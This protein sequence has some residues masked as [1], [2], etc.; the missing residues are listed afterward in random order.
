MGHRLHCDTLTPM[1]HFTVCSFIGNV[2]FLRW[3]LAVLLLSIWLPPWSLLPIIC[4]YELHCP[5]VQLTL[6]L[7]PLSHSLCLPYF[8]VHPQQALGFH[9]PNPILHHTQKFPNLLCAGD[10]RNLFALG[11][12]YAFAPQA[13]AKGS[14]HN[15]GTAV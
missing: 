13:H 5:P 9:K 12:N 1:E 14:V 2:L 6:S 7:Y 8:T 3:S 15:C 4:C 10:A 11:H